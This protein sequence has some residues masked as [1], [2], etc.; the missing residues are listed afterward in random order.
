MIESKA[1]IVSEKR[2]GI[3]EELPGLLLA[4]YDAYARVLPWRDEPTPYRVWV[5]EIMLQQTRVEAVKP[6]YT[7]F[8]QE[9]PTVEA[10]AAAPEE[11]LL[12]LWEGLGYYSRVRNLQKGAKQVM[13]RFGGEIPGS[14]EE[15]LTLPGV[16]E[17]TAGAIASIAFQKAVPAVDGNVLRV[18]SRLKASS[19]NVLSP[20]VKRSW[21]QQV[22]ALIPKDRAGD[23]NQAL[24]ELGATVCLPN[25][26]PR[27]ECCPLL[28]ICQGRK[29]GIAAEL[30]VKA[31]KK[32]RRV[33]ER[34]VFLLTCRGRLALALRPEKGLLA[35]MY[36]LPAAPGH[37]SEKEAEKALKAWGIMPMSPLRELQAAKHIFT[38][39]E[40]QMTGWAAEARE[41]VPGFTWVTG[42][43]LNSEIALPSA[44]R[45][46]REDIWQRLG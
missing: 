8:L 32:P 12:K 33:E 11:Q 36:E 39:V 4:W 38:H 25:G 6:F 16:G 9:L 10:L 17:Y 40:W 34:T 2:T 46:Y 41:P 35:G 21:S 14:F 3:S 44:F 23:F 19:D 45:A 15:L 7:R 20:Q 24:M 5:S 29:L 13:E 28:S 43:E 1:E 22:A 42:E 18:V 27:C 26:A 31:P 30:P 37:L